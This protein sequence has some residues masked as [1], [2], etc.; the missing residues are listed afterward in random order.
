MPAGIVFTSRFKLSF[1]NSWYHF[2]HAANIIQPVIM[3][4]ENAFPC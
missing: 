1:L 4:I 2:L 3:R